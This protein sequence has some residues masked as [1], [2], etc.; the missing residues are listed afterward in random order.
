MKK[1]SVIIPTL[2]KNKNL[3]INLI[4]SV[5]NEDVVDEI[6]LI[7]NSTNGFKLNCDKLRVIIPKENLYV[8]TSWNLGIKEAKNEIIALLNDDITIPGQFC[9][10]VVERM[11]PEIGIVGTDVDWV[12]TTTE[13]VDIQ[14]NIEI[15]LKKVNERCTHLGI[16]LLHHY[17]KKH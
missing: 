11:Y 10:K 2:Q 3:L 5:A 12:V 8:N 14:N 6:I 4:N 9:T 1:L 13:K 15:E 16:E 7:D 17:N